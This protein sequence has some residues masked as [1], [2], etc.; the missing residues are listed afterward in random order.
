MNRKEGHYS[1]SSGTTGCSNIGNMKA[2]YSLSAQEQAVAENEQGWV[3]DDYLFRSEGNLYSTQA[4]HLPVKA[5][6][7]SELLSLVELVELGTLSREE[8]LMCIDVECIRKIEGD[9]VYTHRGHHEILQKLLLWSDQ[10]RT[11]KVMT[12][13]LTPEELWIGKSMGVANVGLVRCEELLKLE[14]LNSI[15]PTGWMMDEEIAVPLQRR[16]LCLLQEQWESLFYALQ[17]VPATISLIQASNFG[18]SSYS[19]LG[20]QDIQIEALFRAMRTCEQQGI[21][22]MVDILVTHPASAEQFADGIHFV[23]QVAEQTLGHIRRSIKYRVGALIPWNIRSSV[24]ADLARATNLLVVEWEERNVMSPDDSMN[25][26]IF[27]HIRQIHP[28][29]HIRAVGHLTSADLP[30]I[31]AFGIDEMSCDPREATV[32]R[33]AAAQLELME[34]VIGF[35]L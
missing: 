10:V 25:M 22:C 21:D 30:A 19:M 1:C 34:K 27:H 12:G 28:R 14:P 13:G 3:Q 35:H 32:I 2:L 9:I 17:G 15:V 33:I 7:L 24:A 31:F 11:L 6:S 20:I 18:T 5:S 23:D 4:D 29:I 16:L 26:G 8:A